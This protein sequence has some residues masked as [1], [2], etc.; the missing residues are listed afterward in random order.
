[1]EIIIKK[2][3]NKK[4]MYNHINTQL[5]TIWSEG[6][7]KTSLLA[8]SSSLLNM[9][10]KDINWAGFYIL[11]G[12]VLQLGPFQGKPAV[13][14]IKIGEGV[15]GTAAAEEKS[16]LIND[17]HKCEGH[18]ACDINSKSEIVIPMFLQGSLIGVLD[19]DSPVYSRFD[20]E[21]EEGLSSFVNKLMELYILCC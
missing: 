4:D 19:I 10:L 6:D 3:N 7:N 17:V 16:Q 2:F 1:M 13:T 9:F 8:N 11:N 14:R 21:D 20:N 15:C 5:K 12:D 18:I